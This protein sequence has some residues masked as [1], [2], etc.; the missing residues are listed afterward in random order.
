[1]LVCRKSGEYDGDCSE[2]D[3]PCDDTSTQM[4]GG[5]SHGNFGSI[6][7]STARISPINLSSTSTPGQTVSTFLHAP[8]DRSEPNAPPAPH[9][10]LPRVQWVRERQRLSRQGGQ[11]GTVGTRVHSE[12]SGLREVDAGAMNHTSV[13]GA[14]GLDMLAVPGL[15]C[16]EAVS[17]KDARRDLEVWNSWTRG[18]SR[19]VAIW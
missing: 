4:Q 14:F 9:V 1:M 12:W 15:C 6:Q 5:R 16:G 13:P 3:H 11:A 19:I 10:L 17:N 2:D 7:R 18:Y 8:S